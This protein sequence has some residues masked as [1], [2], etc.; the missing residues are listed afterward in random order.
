MEIP[1]TTQGADDMTPATEQQPTGT[2]RSRLLSPQPLILAILLVLLLLMLAVALRPEF[3]GGVFL[4]WAL[5]VAAGLV[6]VVLARTAT[7]HSLAREPGEDDVPLKMSDGGELGW[8]VI[9]RAAAVMA[10]L[11][12]A[13]VLLG[14]VVG[15]TIAVFLILLLQMKVSPRTA[16]QF[17]LL[18]GV[19]IPVVFGVALEVNI[20]PGLIPAIIPRWIGGGLLPPL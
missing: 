12:A 9:L 10:A 19:V 14:M 8:M 16:I 18:W 7:G 15:L 1:E 3:R 6:A 20:W 4:T 11:F 5:I 2:A 17:A 13:V